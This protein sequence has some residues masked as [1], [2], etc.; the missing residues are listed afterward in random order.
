M[1]KCVRPVFVQSILSNPIRLGLDENRLDEKWVYRKNGT[2]VFD[3]TCFTVQL[4]LCGI[5]FGFGAATATTV[6]G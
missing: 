3:V 4:S 5:F 6:G 2:E 1:E